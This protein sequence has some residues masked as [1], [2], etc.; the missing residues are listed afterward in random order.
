M[1]KFIA[2]LAAVVLALLLA[3]P[4]LAV[5]LGVSPSH[6]ELEVPGDGSATANFQ[7]HFFSGDLK[8][9]L[10]DIP[11]TVEPETLHVEASDGPVDIE[12]TIYGDESLGS[13]IYD[14]YIRFLGM[15]GGSVGVAVK[16]K[17]K[18]TNLV[19]GETPVLAPPEESPP[20]TEVSTPEEAPATEGPAE[21]LPEEGPSGVQVAEPSQEV[22]KTSPAPTPSVPPAPSGASGLPILPI[23]GIAA[24]TI[25]AVTLIIVIVRR[26]K[27]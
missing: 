22:E 27:Y 25:V 9:S 3:S 5:S 8:V 13:R 24:G 16:V 23:V 11:L 19:E 4:V 15:S 10:V 7:V 17:A 21:T 6:T 14:G 26:Q 1:K 18:V 2:I 20:V 12:L